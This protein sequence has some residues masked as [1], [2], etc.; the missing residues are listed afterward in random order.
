MKLVRSTFD[1]QA[2]GKVDSNAAFLD[3]RFA[4][5]LCRNHPKF[6]KTKA[7]AGFLF[8]KS[9]VDAVRNCC[10]SFTPSTRFYLPF[11]IGKL[12]WIGL[13]L[14]FTAGKLYVFD[15]NAKL[16]TEEA[17]CKDLL[18]ISEMFPSLLKQCRV[19]VE[20]DDKH[21]IVERIQGVAQNNNPGDA[22]ITASLLIQ[23][24]SLFG[25]E[26]CRGIIPSIIPDEAHRAAVMIY[27]FH[28]KL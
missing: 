2:T 16:R 8:S 27:E 10:A 19:S 23:T 12:H 24:H 17:L 15:C 7:K 4:A 26:A 14:D 5:L 6:K 9:M 18:P 28:V 3:S 1:N 11:N 25:T 21:L 13:C 20:G 22:G